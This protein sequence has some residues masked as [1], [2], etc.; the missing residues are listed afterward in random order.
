MAPN[1]LIISN[2]F[3]MPVVFFGHGTPMN[4]LAHNQYTDAWRKLGETVPRPKAILCVSAHWY[5]QGTRVTGDE[6]PRTNHDFGGFPNPLFDIR[7]P[8]PG[9]PRLA[10]RVR[11]LLSTIEV[12]SDSSWGFDHGTWSVLAHAFPH[13]DVPVVQLSIDGTKPPKFHYELGAQLAPLRDEGVLIIGS[14]NIIHNLPLRKWDQSATPYAWALQFNEM[15]CDFLV[16]RQHDRLLD[17]EGMGEAA[18][19][20]VPTPD[21]FLPLLYVIALQESSDKVALLVDG[22]ERGSIGMLTASIGL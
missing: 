2:E 6:S 16:G 12:Q 7:Y 20:S 3:R 17:L 22:I 15:V 5:T 4:A 11:E 18:R 1:E 21:H 9:S 8:A 10:E 14:G 13:A 19:L